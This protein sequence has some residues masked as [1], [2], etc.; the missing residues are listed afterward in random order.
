MGAKLTPEHI[1]SLSQAQGR[2]MSEKEAGF[3]HAFQGFIEDAIRDGRGFVPVIE[4]LRQNI[5]G[6]ARHQLSVAG[7]AQPGI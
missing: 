1:D 6:L 4:T 2:R 7:G 5:R 3:L